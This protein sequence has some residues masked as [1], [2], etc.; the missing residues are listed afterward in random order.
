MNERMLVDDCILQFLHSVF[1]ALGQI[2]L[3]NQFNGLDFELR[4]R[5]RCTEP[6]WIRVNVAPAMSM[7][8]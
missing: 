3:D 8:C 1:N 4:P 6:C 5:L 7:G 2:A